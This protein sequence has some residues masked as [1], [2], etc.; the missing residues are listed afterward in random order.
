MRKRVC[1]RLA[2]RMTELNISDI[3]AY[4][5]YLAQ[6]PDEWQQLDSLCRVVITRFYRDKLVFAELTERVL[7][8]MASAAMANGR[9]QIRMWSIGSASGEEP[10]SLAILWHHH[11]APRFPEIQVSILGTEIDSHLIERAHRACYTQ[12]TLK[13]MPKEL[14]DA[15]FSITEDRYCLK[16]CYQELVEFRQQD[17]R[18]TVPDESFDII[19]CRNLVFTYFDEFQ[20]QMILHRLLGRLLSGGWLVIGVH[21]VIPAPVTGVQTVS[22]RLGLYR[23]I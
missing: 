15:A 18:T 22:K 8:Q 16:L 12:D 10:Y 1:N 14:C 11:L 5:H 23:C 2:D 6:R 7:P 9:P 20:Q 4:Q 13:N 21:E 17:I 3:D 19:L